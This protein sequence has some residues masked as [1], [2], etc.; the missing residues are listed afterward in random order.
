MDETPE[1]DDHI[2]PI[3]QEILLDSREQRQAIATA[4]RDPVPHGEGA[5]WVGEEGVGPR[6]DLHVSRR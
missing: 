6:P 3:G 1:I 2:P 4:Y 5:W